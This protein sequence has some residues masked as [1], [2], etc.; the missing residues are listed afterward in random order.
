M[1]DRVLNLSFFTNHAHVLFCIIRDPKVRLRD[2]ARELGITERT[3]QRIVMELETAG[4]ITR[5]RH[6]RRNSYVV[7][8]HH[9]PRHSIASHQSISAMQDFILHQGRLLV[10]ADPDL[11]NEANATNTAGSIHGAS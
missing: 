8:S 10:G 4:F 6:G 9:S 11:D 2:V 5:Q 1:P 3:V 7:H